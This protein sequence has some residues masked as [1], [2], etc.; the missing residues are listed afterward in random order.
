MSGALNIMW[1]AEAWGD[2]VYWPGQD[3]KT[4][5]RINRKRVANAVLTTAS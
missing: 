5:R 4:L 2:Y 1:T 3:K